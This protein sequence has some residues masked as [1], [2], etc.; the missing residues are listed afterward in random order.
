[1]RGGEGRYGPGVLVVL[2]LLALHRMHCYSRHY[3][4]ELFVQFLALK[5]AK[6]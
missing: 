2:F 5:S 1:M 6:P 4:T 3:A